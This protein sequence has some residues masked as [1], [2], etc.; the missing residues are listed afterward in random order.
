MLN[1]GTFSKVKKNSLANVLRVILGIPLSLFFTY[2]VLKKLSLSDYGAWALSISFFSYFS[3][4]DL[5]LTPAVTRFISYHHARKDQNSVNKI[6]NT[7]LFYYLTAGFFITVILLFLRPLMLKLFFNKTGVEFDQ[8]SFIY[9]VVIITGFIDFIFTTFTAIVNG[10]QRMEITSLIDLVKNTFIPVFG[11]IALLINP[12]LVYFSISFFIS[13]VLW[14]LITYIFTK[15]IVRNMQLSAKFINKKTFLE[16]FKFG[17]KSQFSSWSNYVL[18]NIDKL[19][20]SHFLGID[21]VAYMDIALKVISQARQLINSFIAPILPAAAEKTVLFKNKVRDFYN[22][23]IKFVSI[24]S[25]GVFIALIILSPWLV[26]LWLGP[27]FKQSVLAI[28]ILSIGHCINMLTGPASAILFA[29]N[30]PGP[31]MV[32]AVA[33][34]ILHTVFSVTGIVFFGFTGLLIASSFSLFLSDSI[35]VLIAPR[36]FGKSSTE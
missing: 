20:I 32:L 13:T 15:S 11:L 18:F 16:L 30:K 9:T 31:V 14:A 17:I 4:F 7:A 21:K 6:I 29:Q 33:D 5:G 10:F 35:F 1:F 8:Y 27:G 28:Q 36:F 22:T 12:N 23:S 19:I 3:F 34:S 26:N 25:A 24:A 2:F